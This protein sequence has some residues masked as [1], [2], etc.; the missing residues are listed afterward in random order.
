MNTTA[1]ILMLIAAVAA[2]VFGVLYYARA[3]SAPPMQTKFP[4]A[5]LASLRADLKLL[6]GDPTTER[7]DSV[8][9]TTLHAARYFQREGLISVDESDDVIDKLVKRYAPI[10]LA[11]AQQHFASSTWAS[12]DNFKLRRQAHLLGGLRKQSDKSAILQGE[13][14]AAIDSVGATITAYDDANELADRESFTNVADVQQRIAQ[15]RTYARQ[16]PLSNCTELVDRLLSLPSRIERKHY[17][18]VL[19]KVNEMA[20]YHSYNEDTYKTRV[21]VDAK[22]AIEEYEKNAYKLYGTQNSLSG[23]KDKYNYSWEAA[24]EYYDQQTDDNWW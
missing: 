10:F 9:S 20:Y 6:D 23:L 21:A 4:N 17:A 22:N 8:F 5:H 24:S 3:V 18:Y 11:Q 1:K 13:Q 14:R 19:G 15:A 7:A 2:A 12:A 16:K